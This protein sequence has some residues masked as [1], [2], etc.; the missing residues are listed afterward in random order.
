MRKLINKIIIPC[1]FVCVCAC[2]SNNEEEPK[3]LLSNI[4]GTWD[5]TAYQD[6]AYFIPATN[7][8]YYYFAP[9]GSFLHV[10]E[11]TPE[12][13]DTNAGQYS[14]NP[15]NQTIHVDESNGRKLDIT[16]QFLS[17]ESS[18]SAIF[19]VKGQ[20]TIQNKTIKVQRR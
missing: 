8:E 12:L 4:S 15:D 17:S 19:I 16:V 3:I 13:S 9:D 14:Y 20:T 18:Y 1:L 10:Y 6:G 7:P 5:V 11:Y 2:S